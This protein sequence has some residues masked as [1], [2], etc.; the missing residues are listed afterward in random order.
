MPHT[1][2]FLWF[3]STGAIIVAIFGLGFVLLC[4]I[5]GRAKDQIRDKAVAAEAA[6]Q[7]RDYLTCVKLCDSAIAATRTMQLPPDDLLALTLALRSQ[8]CEDLGRNEEALVSAAQAFACLCRV[9]QARAQLAILDRLGE[10]LLNLH[11]E[12][13]AA[14][15][16]QAGVALGQ[17][18]DPDARTRSARL[19]LLGRAHMGIGRYPSGAVAY[20]QAIELAAKEHGPDALQLASPYINLGNCY[21]RMHKIGDAERCY[22]E[23]LRLYEHHQTTDDEN[24]GAALMNMGVACAETGRNPEAEQYYLRVL[25]MRRAAFGRNDSR[26]GTLYNNLAMCKLRMRDFPA[27]ERYINQALEILEPRPEA[28][29]SATDTLSTIREEQGRLEESLA[30]ASKAREILQ[31]LPS[32]N[33]S[34]LASRFDREAQLLS[35]MGDEEQAA[36]CRANAAQARQVLAAVP[37]GSAQR[38]LEALRELDER[39]KESLSHLSTGQAA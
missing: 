38:T 16:L 20:G 25:D 36:S 34:A 22:R 27:V 1:A 31:N 33:L 29:S 14:G 6:Y 37:E 26:V 12:G 28:L 21:R 18:A 7:S 13:R 3:P 8:A 5:V 23:A 32:P 2:A 9:R 4:W 11:Q 15:V 10:L 30:A 39:L 24:Y 35:R 19:Q 17:Q